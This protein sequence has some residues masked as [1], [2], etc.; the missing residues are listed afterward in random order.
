MTFKL[1]SFLIYI[2]LFFCTVLYGQSGA[3]AAKS[4][5]DAALAARAASGSIGFGPAAIKEARLTKIR[6][7][8]NWPQISKLTIALLDSKESK[9]AI[10]WFF[11][12]IVPKCGAAQPEIFG[13]SW[14]DTAPKFA[15]LPSSDVYDLLER[16]DLYSQYRI[17]LQNRLLLAAQLPTFEIIDKLKVEPGNR[18]LII[19]FLNDSLLFNRQ[20]CQQLTPIEKQVISQIPKLINQ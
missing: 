11:S 10:G 4:A 7:E 19:P 17:E 6:S 13:A 8:Q 1:S 18:Q 16:A 15:K 3:D 2:V 14:E 12:W 5:A 20:E 9:F